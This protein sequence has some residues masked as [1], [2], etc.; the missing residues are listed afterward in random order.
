MACNIVMGFND[1]MLM[2][3]SILLEMWMQCGPSHVKCGCNVDPP[4]L[5]NLNVEQC[6]CIVEQCGF[7]HFKCE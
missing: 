1:Q 6:G 5:H 4:H 3:V 2:N 7:P